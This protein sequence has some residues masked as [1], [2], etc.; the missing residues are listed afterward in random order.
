MSHLGR[1]KGQ[2]KKDTLSLSVVKEYL[3]NKLKRE[4]RFSENLSDALEE[5]KKEG[6]LLLENLRFQPEEEGKGENEKGE[7]IKPDEKDVKIFREKLTQL[8]DVFVNDAFGTAHRAHSS[9]VGVNLK[10][11]VAGLLMAKELSYFSKAL[12]SPQRP[13]CLILGG[14]KV[15]DKIK[16]IHNMLDKVDTMIIG[17]GMAFTFLKVLHGMNI[18][19]SLFDKEGAKLVTDIVAKAQAKGVKLL[20]PEDFVLADKFAAHANV[21][22]SNVK[23]G[24]ETPWM[25]LDIGAKSSKSFAK[26]IMDARTVVWN[27]PMGVFEYDAFSKGSQAVLNAVVEVT[28]SGKATTVIGGGDTATCA[29]K[30]NA[31]G[32]VSH[33]STGGGASL[34]LLEGKVLPGVKALMDI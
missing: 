33:I 10:T 27:G 26:A 9:M 7:K 19:S 15:S 17:G 28:K 4:V 23:D 2:P 30:Y 12:D 6:V 13:F 22:T 11:R 8:G 1:P 24:I 31:V 32:K 16:L 20:L 29:K 21:L 14:A 3:S 34:E 18:G 5:S 25:G